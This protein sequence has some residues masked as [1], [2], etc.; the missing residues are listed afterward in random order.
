MNRTVFK[1]MSLCAWSG[2]KMQETPEELYEDL[3]RG[4]DRLGG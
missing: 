2:R 1:G 4:E 3:S